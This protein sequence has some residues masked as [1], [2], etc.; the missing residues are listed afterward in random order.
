MAITLRA[1]SIL[2]KKSSLAHVANFHFGAFD[3]T[4]AATDS[5][6]LFFK[7]SCISTGIF[8]FKFTLPDKILKL[9]YIL[10]SRIDTYLYVIPCPDSNNC[11]ADKPSSYSLLSGTVCAIFE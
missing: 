4:T 6:F 3:N 7:C 10:P 1:Q 5:D 11:F 8:K 9:Q 2:L